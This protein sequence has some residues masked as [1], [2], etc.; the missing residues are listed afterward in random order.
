MLF[1]AV[2]PRVLSEKSKMAINYTSQQLRQSISTICDRIS[3]YEAAIVSCKDLTLQRFYASEINNLR[4][5]RTRM[6]SLLSSV[7]AVQTLSTVRRLEASVAD[8]LNDTCDALP[9]KERT[10]TIQAVLSQKETDLSDLMCDIQDNNDDSNTFQ[11]SADDTIKEIL[12]ATS[13][14]REPPLTATNIL[15][16]LPAPPTG[17]TAT[18]ITHQTKPHS[19]TQGTAP[20]EPARLKCLDI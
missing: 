9:S 2:I 12:S 10:Q 14:V 13:A 17:F 19:T 18:A 7:S 8:A 6:L 11:P 16:R 4:T 5:S 1:Y 3:E 20:K 15:S